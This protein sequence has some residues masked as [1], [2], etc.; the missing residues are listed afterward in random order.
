[1]RRLRARFRPD[2]LTDRD[3]ERAATRYG[4]ALVLALH[5]NPALA[6][7]LF[8]TYDARLPATGYAS[9]F[10]AAELGRLR[11]LGGHFDRAGLDV[12]IDVAERLG[13]HGIGRLAR[14]TLAR[15]LGRTGEASELVG[16][17]RQLRN[18]GA[19]DIT[20]VTAA[21]EEYTARASLDRDAELWSALLADLPDPLI[22]DRFAVRLFLGWGTDAVRLA[23]TPARKRAA[24][25]CCAR[26]S[27]LPDV[28]AG[29]ELAV[30]DVDD[31]TAQRLAVRA[32]ELLLAKDK[33]EEALTYFV[34]AHRDDRASHCHEQLGDFR[35]ALETC[36][37]DEPD[38]LA[39]LAG[40]CRTEIDSLVEDGE[41][42]VA[43]RR[44][45][46]VL[47]HLD[48]AA[49]AEAVT[50]RREELEGVRQAVTADGR[51]R[52]KGLLAKTSDADA[53][54][55]VHRDWSAFEEEAQEPLEAAR[56]AEDA[57]EYYRAHR[58]YRTAERYG[59]ADRVLH[60]DD[61][62]E[63]LT[64]RAEARE[65]GGDHLG[66]ARLHERAGRHE[67]AVA[68][69]DRVD[70]PAAAA[71]CLIL[72][73]GDEAVEDPRLAGFLRRS[74]DIEEL[75]RRCLDALASRGHASHAESVLRS[76][77]VDETTVTGPRRQQVLDAL[78][79]LETADRGAFE[80]RVGRWV[81]Q[82]R[83]EVDASYSRTWGMDLGTS[84]CVAAVYDKT[85]GI[86]VVCPHAG[87]PSFAATLSVTE[88]GE[89][90]VGLSGDAMLV[91]R[92]T[93][94]V[95]DAKRR[96][97]ERTSYEL[98]DRTY[99][100]E[101][102]SARLISHARTLVEAFL[103]ERVRERIAAL[104][105]AELGE[106][107]DTWLD[108]A[109]ERHELTL[110]RPKVIVTI[111]ANFHNNAK[112]ATRNAC[113]IAGVEAVRLIHEP[114]AACMAVARQQ[115]LGGRV[116]VLDLGA[117]TLDASLVEVEGDVYEVGRV[118]G[119][120]AYGGRDFD[121]AVAD[122]LAGR[123][124]GQGMDI[125]AEGTE[126]RRLEF[127]AEHLKILL[128]S[129]TEAEYPLVGFLGRHG[130]SVGLTRSEL[131]DLLAEPLDTLRRVCER[132]RDG[133]RASAGAPEHLVLVGGPMRSSL[134]T[135]VVERALGCRSR[136]HSD[137]STV[138]AFG[139][140][141]LGGRLEGDLKDILL[142]DVT[143]LALGISIVDR[144]NGGQQFDTLVEANTRIP[145]QRREVYSTAQDDQPNVH[146]QVYN[147]GQ[148]DPSARI[149]QLTLDIPPAPKGV[150]QIEVT[151]EIDASCVLKVTALDKAT[152]KKKSVRITDSTLLSPQEIQEMTQRQARQH[153]WEM[154]RHTL[155]AL[156]EQA[157][158][159]QPER[160]CREFRDR[161]EAH[162]PSGT[163]LDRRSRRLEAEMYGSEALEVEAELLSLSGPLRDLTASSRHYLER[164][165]AA[166]AT[167][168]GRHLAA[169]LGEHVDRMRKGIA[170]MAAWNAFLAAAAAAEV[171][172][173][174]R[175][176]NLERAGDHERAL[177]AL[178]ALTEPLSDPE[179]LRRRLRCLAGA[180][181]FEMYRKTLLA[182]APRLGAVVLD[183]DHPEPYLTA[184]RPALVRVVDEDGRESSGFL[185]SDRH[186]LTAGRWPERPDPGLTVL[187]ATGVRTVSHVFHP[188]SA[189]LDAGVVLLDNR[190]PDRP[191]RLGFPRLTG[192]SSEV[193]GAV[194]DRMLVTGMVQGIEEFSER[195]LK[196]FRTDLELP[197][198][199]GG[200]PL[201]NE[202][203]EVVGLLLA[204]ASG[205]ATFAI[206]LD[207]LAPLFARAG[208]A[209]AESG[210]SG[211]EEPAL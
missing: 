168:A 10:G 170:R 206:S 113:E 45:R 74:G 156:T 3:T 55:A 192:I 8:E 42:T 101:E 116:A 209:F 95:S 154:F 47:D 63:S 135:G 155:M 158:G 21:L 73:L 176:R 202:L 81:A 196:L 104:A 167:D 157:A 138:V 197:P 123:L 111:P 100:P 150:P 128:S 13:D 22:P 83:Q 145:A 132:F 139:A 64:A 91:P 187:M 53:V 7:N 161:L 193:W 140:A 190:V 77:V 67:E 61:S 127:A 162:R 195:G 211:G 136:G 28:Q 174:K 203:G 14:Q 201:L 107:R 24:L 152:G 66:A 43:V 121:R 146:I 103:A 29:L 93:A 40:E 131:A 153:D 52:L 57:E 109:A 151:F 120:S 117:G 191:L 68:L 2:V 30:D 85:C 147:G 159:F 184:A 118:S 34:W 183:R 172:P 50:R 148:V 12:V 99:R 198:D 6:R 160:V 204:R 48:R 71:R 90:I 4:R 208:V 124:R 173:L 182:D 49:P 114:T 9:A 87:Q 210:G 72:W 105:R 102:V 164:A 76:L 171:H 37:A 133:V 186:V 94:S 178:G 31:A 175:F 166:E 89:E 134:V 11:K 112:T 185:I 27:Y 194:S 38:R 189:A 79:A 188:G 199:A 5:E 177:R 126:R 70:D 144:K 75:V 39:R 180:R 62:P 106:I 78:E 179:D 26:S 36:S 143:P 137:P 165:D 44:V 119:D 1:M 108:W 20:I 130:I 16:W 181:G 86:P 169:L 207:S 23:D 65:A 32:G 51:R 25:E 84:T 82:A 80:E 115:E 17:L 98:G 129:Q 200:G 33:P 59:D 18:R 163:P 60:D 141:L 46:A 19:L 97:G 41:H 35:A 56:H 54:K 122:F 125:P 15:L 69:Y 58:L 88:E 149:G 96:M 92:I 142:L 205:K 110:S